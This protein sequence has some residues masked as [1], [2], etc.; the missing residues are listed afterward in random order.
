[1]G[2]R[3]PHTAH[4]Q[5]QHPSHPHIH[6]VPTGL[7][8]PR[9]R[10]SFHHKPAPYA[11]LKVFRVPQLESCLKTSQ[12]LCKQWMKEKAGVCGFNPEKPSAITEIRL[13]RHLESPWLVPTPAPSGSKSNLSQ[14]PCG[15]SIIANHYQWFGLKKKKK[16]PPTPSRISCK[17]TAKLGLLHKSYAY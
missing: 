8:V 9:P 14:L 2:N 6:G 15:T 4:Y 3:P 1:M 17:Q 10:I 13:H 7:R 11:S 16:A 5:L 12:R